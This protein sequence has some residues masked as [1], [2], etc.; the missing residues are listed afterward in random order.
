V[1]QFLNGVPISCSRVEPVSASICWF[2]VGDDP[3]RIGGHQRVDIGLD[4][5]AGVELGRL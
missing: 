3:Q 5:R 1:K 2:D 4:Q